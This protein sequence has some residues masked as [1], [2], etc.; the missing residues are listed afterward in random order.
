MR[1]VRRVALVAAGGVGVLGAPGAATAAAA[2]AQHAPEAA[3]AC[4]PASFACRLDGG[5]WSRCTPPK[6]YRSLAPGSHAFRVRA[7]DAEGHADPTPVVWR[8]RV[9]R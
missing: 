1:T 4:A 9:T 2:P 5:T 6:L 8:W 3:A 7:I